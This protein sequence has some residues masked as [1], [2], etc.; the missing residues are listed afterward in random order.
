[1]KTTFN[2]KVAE[3]DMTGLNRF[4]SEL[5][6]AVLGAG[7]GDDGDVQQ[8]VKVEAGQLAQEISSELG[9]KSLE[10]VIGRITK[11]EKKFLT[12]KPGLD[13][14]E[15]DEEKQYSS[16]ADFTWLGSSPT[17]LLGVNDEDYLTDVSSEDA[18]IIVRAGQKSASGSRGDKWHHVGSR[19]RQDVFIL[20][21]TKVSNAAFVGVRK[22][23]QK[24]FGILK[25]SFALTAQNLLQHS[26]SPAW[27]S[28]HFKTQAEGRNILNRQEENHPTSPSIEFGSTA[29][30]VE[31][32]WTIVG[33]ISGAVE[34]RKYKMKK[35]LE[36]IIAGY[37]YDWN[38]GRVFRQ[39]REIINADV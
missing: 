34:N 28:V 5:L 39:Q 29:K 16:A 37:T 26:K 36:N 15:G 22:L 25:A 3:V 12:V 20:N 38:T 9:P 13:S 31:N 6:G 17:K 10:S 4:A 2:P 23:I 7:K 27:V 14:F 11:D 33:K 8:F 19:G 21:R 35:K 1:M 24:R 32:N 18:L 30:G